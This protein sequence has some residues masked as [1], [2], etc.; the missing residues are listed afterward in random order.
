MKITELLKG[1]NRTSQKR[2]NKL[3]GSLRDNPKILWYPSAGNDYRDILELS[4]VKIDEKNIRGNINIVTDYGIPAP[5]LFIHTDY[6]K[7]MVE[8]KK[9]E[10]FN[11]HKTVVIAKEI[12]PLSIHHSVKYEINENFVDSP[13][14]A[15][16]EPEIYL[17]D[18]EISSNKLGKI[19]KPVI[20]FLFEN[21]NFF[22]EVLLK[23]GINVAYMVKVREG[24]GM[25]GNRKSVTNIYPYFSVVKT[26]YLIADDEIHFDEEDLEA[27]EKN[28]EL[29]NYALIELQPKR[30]IPPVIMWSD[31]QVHVY[32]VEIKEGL[33]TKERIEEIFSPI[34]KR[35]RNGNIST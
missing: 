8:L 16:Q 14:D 5:D 26:E 4:E 15:P 24:C 35:W 11:D 22:Q 20:Y 23:H 33:L 30:Q 10:L 31:F 34:Q 6:N 27:L 19:E 2:L 21:I 32:K 17:L 29:K 1:K 13:Q 18:L 28:K 9:G 7:N 12:Y 3:F 25:G